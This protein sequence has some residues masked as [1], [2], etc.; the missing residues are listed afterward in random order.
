MD[1]NSDKTAYFR[2]KI[3]EIKEEFHKRM[4]GMEDFLDMALVCLLSK[5]LEMNFHILLESPPG[6]GKTRALSTFARV[7]DLKFQRVQMN[8]EK[9]PSEILGFERFNPKSQD[10]EINQGPIFT[11]ILLVDEINRASGKTQSAL[12]ETMEEGQVT[13]G[14]QTFKLEPPFLVM[15][16]QNPLENAD[17][18]RLGAAQLDRFLMKIKIA[19]PD[20]QN[21]RNILKLHLNSEA[22]ELQR[23][24]S[25]SE[26]IQLQDFIAKIV[27]LDYDLIDF[28]AL[29]IEATRFNS[30]K[31]GT[32]T[33]SGNFIVVAAKTWAF[34]RGRNFVS[35]EDIKFMALRIL[36]HRLNFDPSDIEINGKEIAAFIGE[37][38][39]KWRK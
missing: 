1:E 7:L 5:G 22:R 10:I 35:P 6:E 25:R 20:G 4:I 32:S 3:Q 31:Y 17:T 12:L 34:L 19:Y 39:K 14:R 30:Q 36:P 11:N 15:A 28:T 27:Y 29:I 18:Y 33:R 9:T 13:I 21:L 23:V 38:I 2:R 16:S 8:P 37:A 26:I 24:I